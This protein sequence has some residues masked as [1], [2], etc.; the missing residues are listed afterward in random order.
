MSREGDGA[1]RAEVPGGGGERGTG[2]AFGLTGARVGVMA[3]LVGVGY[4]AVTGTNVGLTGNGATDAMSRSPKTT[5]APTVAALDPTHSGDSNW[6]VTDEV[7]Q[8]RAAND[9]VA[10]HPAAVEAAAARAAAKAR[11]ERLA[12]QARAAAKAEALRNAQRDPKSIAKILAAERG[13]G[14]S[15]FQCLNLLWTRESG[16]NYQATNASSGAYGIPQ[17][18]P[19]TKMQSVA[20]DWRTNPVTQIKWGLNYIADTYT[21]PCGAWAHSQA[22]GWY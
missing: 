16:W 13:W 19:G 7:G 20:S 3:M 21:T 6:D 8:I 9:R 1:G 2:A 22:T 18:L 5:S 14:T 12:A 15:Q 17:A 4:V 11:A 10:Q